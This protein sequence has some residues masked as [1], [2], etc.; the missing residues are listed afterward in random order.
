MD[1]YNGSSSSIIQ[2]VPVDPN[3]STIKFIRQYDF[4]FTV[5]Q[6]VIDYIVISLMDDLENYV[7]FNNQ[8]WNLVL[9]FNILKDVDRFHYQNSFHRILRNGYDNA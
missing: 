4:N 1:S 3:E 8:H 2:S 7:N 5:Y 9:Q 6:D